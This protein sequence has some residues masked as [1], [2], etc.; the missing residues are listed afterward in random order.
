MFFLL[1]QFPVLMVVNLFSTD[2]IDLMVK[3]NT[4]FIS[5]EWMSLCV[6]VYTIT[7]TA[8]QVKPRSL[9]RVYNTVLKWNWVSVDAAKVSQNPSDF[10]SFPR[11]FWGKVSLM[12]EH[13]HCLSKKSW[14][15]AALCHIF[16]FL[17]FF[18]GTAMLCPNRFLLTNPWQTW[19]KTYQ[20]SLFTHKD[21]CSLTSTGRMSHVSLRYLHQENVSRTSHRHDHL[22]EI[23]SK[24]PST[25]PLH[26]MKI[27]DSQSSVRAAIL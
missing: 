1:I 8:A 13:L 17:V 9:S 24:L 6:C 16:V 2:T 20:T 25:S 19:N 12:C 11:Y 27:N 10:V 21:L 18:F 15:G 23:S 14:S 4:R 5:S 7:V 26:N 22:P 3:G